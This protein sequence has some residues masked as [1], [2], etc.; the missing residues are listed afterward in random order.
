MTLET[1]LET[2]SFYSQFILQIDLAERR[3]MLSQV[4]L[5]LMAQQDVRKRELVE[6]L[7]RM[8]EEREGERKDFWLVQYQR[9][10]DTQPENVD[11]DSSVDPELGLNFLTN[12]VIHCLPFLSRLWQDQTKT[13]QEIDEEELKAA[14]I[15]SESDRCGILKSIAQFLEYRREKG[16]G[17]GNGRQVEEEKKENLAEEKKVKEEATED[18]SVDQEEQLAECVI[19]MDKKVREWREFSVD[20]L[21]RN[22]CFSFQVKIIFL[23]CGH[24]ACCD[25][26]HESVTT[27]PMCRAPIQQRIRVIQA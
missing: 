4:L 13:L 15:R 19:C 8:E 7:A 17:G 1:F 26:C 24:L 10:L 21:L 22:F 12:G 16:G 14:G 27:C 9:L 2:F 11:F 3:V 5:E 25:D 20:F 6:M 23:L 18:R